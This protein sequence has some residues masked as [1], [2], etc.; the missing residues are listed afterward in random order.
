MCTA[1]RNA[2]HAGVAKRSKFAPV[3]PTQLCMA[4][5]PPT[6]IWQAMLSVNHVLIMG[7]E[8]RTLTSLAAL[9]L[10]AMTSTMCI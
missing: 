1:R 6:K 8:A 4:M 10:G 9:L 3:V 7:G 5:D 2:V